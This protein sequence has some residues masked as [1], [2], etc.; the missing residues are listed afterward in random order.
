MEARRFKIK[1]ESIVRWDL[2]ITVDGDEALA[3][4]AAKDFIEEC[5]QVDFVFTEP[6]DAEVVGQEDRI[7]LV[8][9]VS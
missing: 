8:R 1:G 5:F 9:E 2:T 4:S 7:F 3:R 6:A